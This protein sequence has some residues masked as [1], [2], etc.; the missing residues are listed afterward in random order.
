L[1]DKLKIAIYSFL[2]LRNGA[3]FERWVEEVAPRLSDIGHDVM[4]LTSKYG[5]ENDTSIRD[6]VA[7]SKVKIYEFNNY[8]NPFKIPKIRE[9]QNI[10]NLIS[11]IDVLYF[12][13]AFALNE[14][15]IEIFRKR[16]KAKVI[17]GHHGT[18]PEHGSIIRRS[19]HR[20]IN[21]KINQRYDG[22]HVLN[23]ERE[24][25][26]KSFGYKNIHKIP[27]GVDTN[28][29]KPGAKADVFTIMFAG[30]M[31]YQ[32]GI[33]RLASV[34]KSINK[35]LDLTKKEIQFL[36]YGS[37]PLSYI[38]EDLQ[39]KFDNVKYIGYSHGEEL[40]M[41][42]QK[43]HVLF[44]PSRYE[45][46][47]LVNLEAQSAGTPVIASDIPGPRE[48]IRNHETGLLV[49]CEALDE[50]I[51]PLLYMKKIYYSNSEEYNNCCLRAR[52]N[53]LEYNWNKVI[54]MFDQMLAV[55]VLR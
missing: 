33:D 1:D 2:N 45:E 38:A 39:R 23:H 5:N 51:K 13:N 40:A 55:T 53:A 42:F 25:V 28:K 41:A 47:G 30:S 8:T 35:T 3:G 43:A 4:V 37:G 34:I 27:Y 36:V 11:E 49:N 52:R 9:V 31:F 24:I 44:S 21:K 22:H 54:H 46:F 32:K 14:V 17:S 29:F 15:I 16:N 20:F 10:H 19:Y 26:L 7:R 50:M 12:N 6:L 48:I 18:F